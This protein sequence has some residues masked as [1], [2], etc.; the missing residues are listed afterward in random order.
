MQAFSWI[1]FRLF[2]TLPPAPLTAAATDA[3]KAAPRLPNR[4]G[5]KQSG[6]T[7]RQEKPHRWHSFNEVLP[8]ASGVCCNYRGA[9][10]C[11][12]AAAPDSSA[13]LEQQS[14]QRRNESSRAGGSFLA[15]GPPSQR[16]HP[17]PAGAQE[18]SEQHEK[19]Q[20]KRQ[21]NFSSLWEKTG[22]SGNLIFQA[23][24]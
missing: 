9:A 3:A 21:T 17:D 7:Q 5:F 8:A 1:S 13:P 10:E 12:A 16:S 20:G 6:V 14:W 4:T 23:L 18:L 24:L 22:H 19:A 11:A 15:A 2:P